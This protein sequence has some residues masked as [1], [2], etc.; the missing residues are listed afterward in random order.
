VGTR[1]HSYPSS[2]GDNARNSIVDRFAQGGGPLDGLSVDISVNERDRFTR[3]EWARFLGRCRATVATEAG[4]AELVW[5]DGSPVSG[6][7]VSSRHFEALGT[8]TVQIMF[9]GRFNDILRAGEHYLLLEPDFGNLH[10]V[11]EALRNPVAL[12]RI[13]DAAHEFALAGHT[14][15]HRARHVLAA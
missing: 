3:E 10:E 2:L 5:G 14:Y 1:T 11:C 15:A 13:T 4:A 7:A 6:K 12:S 9:P 8:K